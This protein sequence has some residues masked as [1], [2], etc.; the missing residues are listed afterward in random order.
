MKARMWARFLDLKPVTCPTKQET[1][2]CLGQRTW[3]DTT[4]CETVSLPAII[5]LQYLVSQRGRC[6]I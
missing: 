3:G 4:R 1:V 2:P 6:L 5:T